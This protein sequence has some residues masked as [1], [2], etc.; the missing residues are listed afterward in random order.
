MTGYEA[1]FLSLGTALAGTFITP[2]GSLIFFLAA[3]NR[4]D[5]AE[6]WP[7]WILFITFS[8]II[9]LTKKVSK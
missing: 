6:W 2:I 4:T 3:Y 9:R 7:L 8:L 1:L 5:P